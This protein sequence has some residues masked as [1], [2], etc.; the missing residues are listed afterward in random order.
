MINEYVLV[1]PD[2]CEASNQ[3]VLCLGAFRITGKQ[4]GPRLVSEASD[5]ELEPKANI[6]PF[7]G[8]N[9]PITC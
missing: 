6:S 2:D 8:K 4:Q 1:F 5:C 9:V 7:A 3:L